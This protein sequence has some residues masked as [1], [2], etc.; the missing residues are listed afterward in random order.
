MAEAEADTAI[1]VVAGKS[2][3]ELNVYDTADYYFRMIEEAELAAPHVIFLAVDTLAARNLSLYGYE[4]DTSPNLDA[5]AGG[6]RV[7]DNARASSSW[8]KPA[9]ATTTID[10]AIAM[11]KTWRLSSPINCATE[12]LS[13]VARKARPSAVR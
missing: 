12:R 6:A 10:S 5:F 2:A 1:W 8:T 11:P 13:E 9:M 7:F 3:M 4:R